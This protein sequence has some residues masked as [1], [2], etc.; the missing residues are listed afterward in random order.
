MSRL[1]SGRRRSPSSAPPPRKRAQGNAVIDNLLGRNCASR[2]IPVHR[3][4]DTIQGQATVAS[5]EDLPDD[6]DL[7]VASVPAGAAAATARALEGRGVRSA[8]FFASRF[9][10]ADE[11]AFRAI[12]AA[13]PMAIQGPN[14]MGLIN[15]NDGLFLYPAT[16]SRQDPAGPGRVH[17]AVRLGGD[18]ADELGGVR[19]LEDRHRRQRV[20]ADRIP[21]HGLAGNRRRHRGGRRGAGGDQDPAAFARAARRIYDAGKALGWC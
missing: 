10:P 5:I 3:S 7:A 11:A 17:R 14:C 19:H 8:I 2:I 1:S 6:V 9:A 13:S 4:A 12:A 18:H 15:L 20:P 21:L 16:T